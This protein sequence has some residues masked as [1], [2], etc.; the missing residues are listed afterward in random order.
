MKIIRL[1]ILALFSVLAMVLSPAAYTADPIRLP[2]QDWH[3]SG[4]LGTFDRASLQRGYMIYRRI[5]AAC[6][7]M[8][9]V[10][11]RN[12][13]DIG[14]SKTQIKA[15]SA[16]YTYTDGPDEQGRMYER[17]GLPSDYFKSPYPNQNAARAIH[18]GALPP[19]LSLIIKA[20]HHGPDHVY[21]ILTGYEEAPEGTTLRAG[22]YW[23]RYMPGHIIA[24]APPLAENMIA[25]EDGTPQ[26]REQYARDVVTF[27]TWAA[28]P[29]LEDRKRAGM[30]AL[31]FLL[32]F[33]GIMY[34][35]QKRIWAAVR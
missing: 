14:Y 31:L 30:K 23:N 6:H 4:P 29:M 19:D 10:A 7:S 2:R 32:V 17:P 35:I 21:G 20:R 28:E 5:C 16:E 12:L 18:N 3:F 26:T 8:K 24:M 25:Y 13:E 1:F 15:I 9:Y 34:A 22:Q 11:F 27:L 33:T